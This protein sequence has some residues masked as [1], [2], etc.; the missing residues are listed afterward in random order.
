MVKRYPENPAHRNHLLWNLAFYAV[1]HTVV[2]I[3]TDKPSVAPFCE[4][5]QTDSLLQGDGVATPTFDLTYTIQIIPKLISCFPSNTFDEILCHD[6]TTVIASTYLLPE[7]DPD[8]TRLAEISDDKLR[9]LIL[10]FSRSDLDPVEA[11]RQSHSA[12]PDDEIHPSITALRR[13]LIPHFPLIVAVFGH[14]IYSR[15]NMRLAPGK[16]MQFFQL[17]QPGKITTRNQKGRHLLDPTPTGRRQVHTHRLRRRRRSRR[18]Q[19]FHNVRAGP[20][21]PSVR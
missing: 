11:A 9:S 12:D 1:S 21:A 3:Q 20:I 15:L 2:F 4:T 17:P 14:L 8:G 6:D 18:R 13:Y 5:T 7:D 10:S 16:K 19:R